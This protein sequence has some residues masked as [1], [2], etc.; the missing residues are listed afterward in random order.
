MAY[1]KLPI[2]PYKN[3]THPS[4]ALV[5]ACEAAVHCQDR[6]ALVDAAIAKLVAAH[7]LFVSTFLCSTIEDRRRSCP[8]VE[9]SRAAQSPSSSVPDS[10][11][12]AIVAGVAGG[13]PSHLFLALFFHPCSSSS[14][15]VKEMMNSNLGLL[16]TRFTI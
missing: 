5:P 8:E 4:V 1:V 15:S 14:F 7:P 12:L 2:L 10:P 13:E 6:A 9:V 3:Q 16:F 11:L